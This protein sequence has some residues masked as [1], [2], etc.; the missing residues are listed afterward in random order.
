M[1]KWKAKIVQP[2]QNWQNNYDALGSKNFCAYFHDI[3]AHRKLDEETY[4]QDMEISG[5]Y[6]LPVLIIFSSFMIFFFIS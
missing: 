1:S 2:D 3:E 5:N 6:C 4:E